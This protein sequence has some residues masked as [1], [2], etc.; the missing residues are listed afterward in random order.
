MAVF[1]I[2][3]HCIA[4]HFSSCVFC[5]AERWRVRSVADG[6][7]EGVD[8]HRTCAFVRRPRRSDR[9]RQVQRR[10]VLIDRTEEQLTVRSCATHCTLPLL[11]RVCGCTA[12]VQVCIATPNTSSRTHSVAQFV[13]RLHLKIHFHSKFYFFKILYMFWRF[14]CKQSVEWLVSVYYIFCFFLLQFKY[15][16]LSTITRRSMLLSNDRTTNLHVTTSASSPT[17]IQFFGNVKSRKP[18]YCVVCCPG[19]Y[20]RAPKCVSSLFCIVHLE[21]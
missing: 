15:T 19:N 1:V 7:L 18:C 17:F 13:C 21:L 9:V 3:S 12:L 20:L 10:G 6:E 4:S 11:C 8:A 2:M 16:S 5:V 14:M